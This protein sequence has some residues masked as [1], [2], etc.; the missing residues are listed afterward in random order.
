MN[1]YL[2]KL[3]FKPINYVY[4]VHEHAMGHGLEPDVVEL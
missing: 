3:Q 2:Y 4:L 1:V